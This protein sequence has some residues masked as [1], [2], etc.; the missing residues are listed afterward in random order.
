MSLTPKN[1]QGGRNGHPHGGT[2]IR[3]A[4]IEDREALVAL[5]AR[6]ATPSVLGD[7]PYD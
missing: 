2:V 4:V 7:A 1:E 6:L 3:P 5:G